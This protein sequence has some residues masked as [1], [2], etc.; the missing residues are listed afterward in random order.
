MDPLVIHLNLIVY[1]LLLPSLNEKKI[2]WI[3]HF[4]FYVGCVIAIKCVTDLIIKI[5]I[6]NKD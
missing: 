3:K 2:N 5:L 6:F 4:R 1:Q